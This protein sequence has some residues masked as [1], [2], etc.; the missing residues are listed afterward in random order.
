MNFWFN[1]ARMSLDTVASRFCSGLREDL[2][3]ELFVWDIPILEQAYQLI[4]DLGRSQGFPFIR[5]TDYR[6]KINKATTVKC[7]LVSP[8]LSPVL[9]LVTLL[10]SMMIKS[11]EFTVSHLDRFNRIDVLSFKS[12]VALLHNVWAK[13]ELWLLRLSRTVTKMT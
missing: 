13:Q 9:N 1:M 10:R 4:Q 5:R 3:R 6:D 2:K 12:L 7:Q 11:K 8:N